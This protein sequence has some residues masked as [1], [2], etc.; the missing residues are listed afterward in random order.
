[1]SHDWYYK[2]MGEEYGPLSSGDLQQHALDGRVTLETHVRRSDGDRWVTADSVKGLFDKPPSQSR[3]CDSSIPTPSASAHSLNPPTLPSPSSQKAA[4]SSATTTRTR[5]VR[6]SWV[7]GGAITLLAC[8]AVIVVFLWPSGQPRDPVS[9]Y[10]QF[11]DSEFK[12]IKEN[13]PNFVLDDKYKLDVQKTDSLVSPLVGTCIVDVLQ[14][15]VDEESVCVYVIKLDMKHAYQDGKWVLT[16]GRADII[17]AKVLKDN[18]ENQIMQ[19]VMDA[20]KREMETSSFESLDDLNEIFG[21]S[22]KE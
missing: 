12:R 21:K 10:T 11:L 17:D 16:A 15:S 13:V 6:V 18:T 5:S 7:V 22:T 4:K 3:E 2:L 14:P 19:E 9:D 20:V 8:I 1:M